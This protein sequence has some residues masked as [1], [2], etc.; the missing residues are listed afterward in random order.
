MV[1]SSEITEESGIGVIENIVKTWEVNECWL[2][3]IDFMEKSDH[4]YQ[5]R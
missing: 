2:H 1:L 4:D 3:C 5:F